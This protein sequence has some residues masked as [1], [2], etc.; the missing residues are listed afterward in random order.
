VKR[1]K[2]GRRRGYSDGCGSFTFTTNSAL[3]HTSAAE[4]TISAPA[5]AVVFVWERAGE[6]GSGLRQYVVSSLGESLYAAWQKANTSFVV[7]N[8]FRDSDDH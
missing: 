3:D 5:V 7:F 6:S 1:I 2:P 8:L 4:G